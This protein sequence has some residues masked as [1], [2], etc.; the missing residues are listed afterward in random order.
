MLGRWPGSHMQTILERTLFRIDV[1][2]LDI[3]IDSVSAAAVRPYL[4]APGSRAR[5]D[6]IVRVVLDARSALA[7][8][9]FLRRVGFG[10]FLGGLRDEQRHAVEAGLLADSTHRTISASLPEWFSFLASRDIVEG[11]EMIY[12]FFADTVRSTYLDPAGSILMD[13][14]DVGRER[15]RSVLATWFAPGS[16]FRDGL[17]GSLQAGHS[18]A[19]P[20]VCSLPS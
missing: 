6:A 19:D 3:C 14:T 16:G 7:R 20:P 15:R 18:P 17:L 10:Q 12:R 1:A 4:T 2:A 5:D 9:R 11:D 8:L 13:R